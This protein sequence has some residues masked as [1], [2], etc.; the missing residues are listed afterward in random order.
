[1]RI[2]ALG[3]KANTVATFF[4]GLPLGLGDATSAIV[5]GE[6][7][8]IVPLGSI[9]VYANSHA[10]TIPVVGVANEITVGLY[11]FLDRRPL[12]GVLMASRCL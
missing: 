8:G 9:T 4:R 1:M 5:E 7:K 12:M 11:W 6:A 2:V 10:E 3:A